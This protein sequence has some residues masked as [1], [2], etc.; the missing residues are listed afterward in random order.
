MSTHWKGPK[1]QVRAL[2]VYIKLMRSAD[3]I[4]SLLQRALA[5]HNLTMSQF[6]A[7]DALHHLGP[8]TSS[9]LAK[10]ILRSGGNVTTVCD[11]LEER[12]LVVRERSLADRRVVTLHLTDAGRELVLAVLPDHVAEITSIVA[13]LTPAEQEMLAALTKKLGVAAASR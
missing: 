8:L 13:A 4:V 2:D 7:L 5:K 9:N 10:K 11:N 1:D 3:T 6:G 12:G